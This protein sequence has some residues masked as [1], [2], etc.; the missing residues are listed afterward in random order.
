MIAVDKGLT[1]IQAHIARLTGLSASAVGDQAWKQ[2]LKTRME[3]C[4]L[5]TSDLYFHRLKNSWM[6]LKQL[7]DLLVNAETW[8]FRD[9]PAMDFLAEQIKQLDKQ[10][11]E[12]WRILS[13]ACASGEEPYSIAMVLLQ[14]SIPASH[15]HIE[16]LDISHRVLQKAEA[17]LYG[18]YSFRG[19]FE[20]YLHFFQQEGGSYRVAPHVRNCVRFR[21]GNIVDPWFFLGGWRFDAIFCRNLLIYQT[22]AAQEQTLARCAS[23][24]EPKGWLLVGPSEG[25]L[26]KSAGFQATTPPAVGAFRC[27]SGEKK[28]ASCDSLAPHWAT[29]SNLMVQPTSWSH[30]KQSASNAEVL[31]KMLLLAAEGHRDEAIAEG[32]KFLEGNEQD[33]AM[34]MLMGVLQVL[35]EKDHIARLHFEKLL[36]ATPYQIDGLINLALIAERRGNVREAQ[37]LWSKVRRLRAKVEPS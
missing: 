25:E 5:P 22:K 3:H 23:L 27:P 15:F 2:S 26:A 4:G 7:V 24:L 16:G 9:K 12:P 35:A 17:G 20:P 34:H 32:Q 14:A 11:S 30:L 19:D 29:H 37:E 33:S 6:E 28:A 18:R 36:E 21:L 8:F 31:H 13:V 10:R 1:E